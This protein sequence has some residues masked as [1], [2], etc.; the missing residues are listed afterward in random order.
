MVNFYI[1]FTFAVLFMHVA[2]YLEAYMHL[3]PYDRYGHGGYRH[4]GYPDG[5]EDYYYYDDDTGPYHYNDPYS[6]QDKEDT[7]M[8]KIHAQREVMCDRGSDCTATC[9]RHQPPDFKT[10]F[11]NCIIYGICSRHFCSCGCKDREL[12]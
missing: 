3:D 4:A 11:P 5:Y 9:K 12:R 2:L 7:F 6:S 8:K 1:V 10:K